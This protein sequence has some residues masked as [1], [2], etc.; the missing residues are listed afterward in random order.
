[1][2]GTEALPI[3]WSRPPEGCEPSTISVSLT[4]VA[5]L[6]LVDN[7]NILPT[8]KK[9]VGLDVGL[10]SLLV[11]DD[12]KKIANPRHFKSLQK[13]ETSSKALDRKQK[14]SNNEQSKGKRWLKARLLIA[15]KI[16]SIN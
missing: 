11:T 15:V 10:S 7:P 13:T 4:P 5:L 12:G 6:A 3:R 14:G 1:V 9:S 8:C 2:V 16:F